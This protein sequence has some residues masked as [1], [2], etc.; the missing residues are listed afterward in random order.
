MWEM[1]Q[2]RNTKEN[3]VITRKQRDEIV[4]RKQTTDLKGSLKFKKN[5]LAQENFARF[6]A[7]APNLSL[8]EIYS[9]SGFTSTNY[10]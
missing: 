3:S 6:V 2:N 7:Q 4:T 10:E 5:G 8:S 1:T 9:F